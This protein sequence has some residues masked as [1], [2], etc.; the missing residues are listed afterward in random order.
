MTANK[1]INVYEE[2]Q[3]ILSLVGERRNI[4]EGLDYIAVNLDNK[5]NI[6]FLK[7]INDLVN[8]FEVFCN[9]FS[10]DCNDII[11]DIEHG[12][13]DIDEITSISINMSKN[14][15]FSDLGSLDYFFI[16]TD[17]ALN[18]LND[19]NGVLAG[20]KLNIG[21]P[22]CDPVETELLNFIPLERNMNLSQLNKVEVD[23]NIDK[24]VQLYLSYNKNNNQSYFYNPYSFIIVNESPLGETHNMIKEFFFFSM[25]NG[26]ADKI[27]ENHF[28]L[29][30]EKNIHILKNSNFRT[31]NY[32]D[33]VNILLF[34]ISEEKYM[35]KYL[36]MKKVFSFYIADDDNIDNLNDKLPNIYKTIKHYYNHYIEDDIKDFFKTKD[37][38]LKEAMSV[39][40]VIYEQTDKINTSITASLLSIILILVT[41]FYRVIDK[42]T[43]TYYLVITTVFL[44]FSIVYYYLTKKTSEKRYELTKDQFDFFAKE[45]SLLKEDEIGSLKDTY[46]VNPYEEMKNT[47][48]RLRYILVII[49]IFIILSFIIYLCK[50]F[51]FSIFA[52]L[53]EICLLK[54]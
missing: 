35:E 37:Q 36:I 7:E 30:G 44:L 6:E 5:I 21:I 17:S 47:I 54:E 13:I 53:K 33:F 19:V 10:E 32:L 20:Y 29:R 14:C 52:Q 48:K 15:C 34:L 31:D 1:M 45:M 42:I 22:Y 25:L 51:D 23:E 50:E 41:T 4:V 27:E 46:L 2:F 38:L 39:S 26:L 16:N 49:N 8:N 3:A 24:K 18:S 40:K 28:V 43:I 12:R 11:Y 9:P